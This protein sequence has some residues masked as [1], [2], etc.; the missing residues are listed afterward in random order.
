MEYIDVFSG[1]GGIG[2][3]LSSYIKPILYC[4]WDRYCQ[5]VLIDRMRDGHLVKAPIHSDIKTLH[6]SPHMAPK[7]IGGGFPCQDI[8]TAGAQ[9]GM[10]GDRSSL[11]FE[12]MRIV[13]E[14]P[15]ID[16]VFL[17]NVANITKCGFQEVQEELQKR[18][19]S[20]VWTVRSAAS[21]GAPHQRSRWFCLASRNPSTLPS[22]S[23]P[24]D[25]KIKD[26][27]SN[28][29]PRRITMKNDPGDPSWDPNW[30]ARAHTLGNSVV[31]C[32]VQA[33]FEE[34]L[35]VMSNLPMVAVAMAPY[36][37]PA[38]VALAGYPYPESGILSNHTFVPLPSHKQTSPHATPRLDISIRQ[39]H[40]Q[41]QT[42][43][44]HLSSYPTLRRGNTHPSNLTDRSLHDLPTVLCNTTIA[45]EQLKAALG[46]DTPP[47]ERLQGLV[48]P[49]TNYLE[50]MMGYPADWTK[51]KTP[52]PT[53]NTH[54]CGTSTS[55]SSSTSSFPTS[56]PNKHAAQFTR[57]RSKRSKRADKP[58]RTPNCMHLFMK[59]TPG[60]DVRQVALL[61]RDLP[62]EKK[63]PYRKRAEELLNASQISIENV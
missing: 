54:A 21:M 47:P 22:S 62:E 59:D 16:H 8:S 12:I 20:M 35:G 60:K 17:E 45:Q 42:K 55:S 5:Q 13:D 50:W 53:L 43:T 44:I 1:I 4:E 15:T 10:A 63:M 2:L 14:A 29:W 58:K 31:P 41:G 49:N 27:W 36:A 18:G 48:I 34:L 11:F 61:W 51:I 40:A 28:E 46:P 25:Q 24:Q 57:P 26:M 7:M 30:I 56:A 39:A 19:F 9:V 32:V 23:A 52:A 37:Q 3:A 38:D 33:A 6:P